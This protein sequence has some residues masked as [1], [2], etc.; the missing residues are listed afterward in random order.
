MGIGSM[1]RIAE[2][3][4]AFIGTGETSR[5]LL[6]AADFADDPHV[7]SLIADKFAV[8]EGA[9]LI[10]TVKGWRHLDSRPIDA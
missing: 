5:N 6:K 9:S 3:K 4:L 7:A 8:V 1:D 10:C 2:A